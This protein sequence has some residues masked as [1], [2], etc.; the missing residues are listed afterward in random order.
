MKRRQFIAGLGGA[1]AW[2]LVAQAQTTIPVIG[3]LHS[4]SFERRRDLLAV[5]LRSLAE[6]GYGE[7]RNV[8]IEYRWAD[9]RNERLPRLAADLVRRRVA[10]M[11]TPTTAAT[12][13]AKAATDTILIVFVS[14]ADPIEI[15]LVSSLNRPGTNLTGMTIFGFEMAAKR[16]EML[17]AFVPT[18]KLS[19]RANPGWPRLRPTRSASAC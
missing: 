6:T 12:V 18:T 2:P 11:V 7:G 15:G 10:V 16:L 17:H 13:A 19:P 4:S 1:A 5:F 9:D 8:A 14:G 3:Y